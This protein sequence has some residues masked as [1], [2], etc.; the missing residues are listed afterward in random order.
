MR[1]VEFSI[2]HQDCW[3]PKTSEKFPEVKISLNNNI[4]VLP[5]IQDK[6]NSHIFSAAWDFICNDRKE[7]DEA[8]RHVKGLASTVRFEPIERFGNRFTTFL[9]IKTDSSPVI[10]RLLERGCRVSES[11]EILDG[12]EQ[13]KVAI[14][15]DQNLRSLVSELSKEGPIKINRIGPEASKTGETTL[16]DKQMAA[17]QTAVEGGYYNWPR[18]Q[19]IEDL[20]CKLALSKPAF[21]AHLR[22]AEARVIPAILKQ[23][24]PPTL[25]SVIP[26]R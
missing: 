25:R 19:S 14:G 1:E 8:V 16:T 9:A 5:V 22:K 20:A 24:A 3:G 4:A 11:L 12:V 21:L 26:S 6:K 10:E 13:W 18:S 23:F 2:Y 15:E 17:L 7:L